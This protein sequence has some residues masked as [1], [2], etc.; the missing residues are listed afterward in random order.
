MRR[1]PTSDI[2]SLVSGDAP[3]FDLSESYGPHAR[4]RDIVGDDF[5]D[6]AEIELGYGT[7]QGDARVRRIV[8]QLHG[9]DADDVVLTNGGIQALFLLGY[10]LCQPGDEAV[11]G[12]PV[13]P[14]ARNALDSVGADVRVVPAVF[15]DGYCVI[16]SAVR[17]LLTSKT[18]PTVDD[19]RPHLSTS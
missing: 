13:F 4:L 1:L 8:G 12:S 16:P 2:I 3:R 15:D 17:A 9:V 5:S 18:K 11:I 10:I 19:A 6:L 14:L 7:A